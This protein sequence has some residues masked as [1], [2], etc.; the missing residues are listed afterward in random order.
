VERGGI[1]PDRTGPL[2]PPATHHPPPEE[3]P[4]TD[5]RQLLG[6]AAKQVPDAKGRVMSLGKRRG[7]RSKIVSWTPIQVQAAYRYARVQT[8]R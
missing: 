2:P 7:F 5:G 8:G 3:D 6:W 1:G 4:P